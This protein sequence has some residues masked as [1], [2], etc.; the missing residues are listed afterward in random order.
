[1]NSKARST[2]SPA[3]SFQNSFA[4]F[5]ALKQAP[6]IKISNA[7]QIPT[8]FG[9]FGF[10]NVRRRTTRRPFEVASSGLCRHVLLSPVWMPAQPTSLAMTSLSKK[11]AATFRLSAF[12]SQRIGSVKVAMEEADETDP[13][14]E[15]KETRTTPRPS[16]FARAKGQLTGFVTRRISAFKGSLFRR[17]VEKKQLEE[18]EELVPISG[19]AETILID[20][21]IAEELLLYRTSCLERTEDWAEEC[22]QMMATWKV[23]QVQQMRFLAFP[24]HS[25]GLIAAEGQSRTQQSKRKKYFSL[26]LS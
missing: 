8:T 10:S 1:M 3:R 18:S 11:T 9:L 12:G 6:C 19:A 24:F 21:E 2:M 17:E 22:A 13:L 4:T 7:V 14:I 20:P 5:P 15:P 26:P 25:N 23:Q 16:R